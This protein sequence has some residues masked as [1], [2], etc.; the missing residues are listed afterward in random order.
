M[1]IL[2]RWRSLPEKQNKLKLRYLTLQ[3]YTLMDATKKEVD[4]TKRRRS[5]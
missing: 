5:S 4:K 1:Y 3:I 2:L